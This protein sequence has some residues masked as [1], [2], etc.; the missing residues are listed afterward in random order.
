MKSVLFSLLVLLS[1]CILSAQ[2]YC[3]TVFHLVPGSARFEASLFSGGDSVLSVDL[4][5][6]SAA[7]SMAY[8]T[9]K[10]VALTALPAGMTLATSSVSFNTVFA[11]AYNPGDTMPVLFYYTVSQPIPADYMVWFRM[12]ADADNSSGVIDSCLVP[13]SFQVNLNPSVGTEVAEDISSG[14]VIRVIYDSDRI[15]IQGYNGEGLILDMQGRLLY[16]LQVTDTRKT[17]MIHLD[18]GIYI[19]R[20]EGGSSIRFWAAD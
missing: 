3:D 2:N 12:Y 13:D 5:N 20:G 19:F 7:Q 15:Q 17:F 11:S 9:A 6:I 8:P 14:E 10:I 1:P 16:T 18:K 4:S